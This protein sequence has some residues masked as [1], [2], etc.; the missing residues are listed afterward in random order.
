MRRICGSNLT[1][2]GCYQKSAKQTIEIVTILAQLHLDYR[3]EG[4]QL[5]LY[6]DQQLMQQLQSFQDQ[7]ENIKSKKKKPGD[8]TITKSTYS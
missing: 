4:E 8:E 6:L 3:R 1:L 5:T 7:Q 2:D